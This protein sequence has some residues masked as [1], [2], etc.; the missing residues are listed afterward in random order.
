MLRASFPVREGDRPVVGV[1]VRD[2]VFVRLDREGRSGFGECAP[3]GGGDAALRACQR[4]LEAWA[5][6]GATADAA[7]CLPPP[8]RFAASAAI[9][10][11]EGFGAAAHAPV[12]AAA[13]F[14]A[15]P[16]ALDDAALDR[17]R[18]GAAIK[19]KIGRAPAAEERRMLE[20]IL[21][22]IPGTRLRLDGNRGMRLDDCVAL[23]QG[24]PV[25]RFEYLEEPV[26]DPSDLGRLRDCTGIDVALDE[27]VVDASAEARDL[28]DRLGGGAC[29]WVIR[30]SRI[31]SLDEVRRTMRIAASR[32]CDPVLSTAYESSWTIRLAAH[33]ARSMDATD[34]PHGLGTADVLEADACVPA[35][36]ASECVPCGPLPV[37]LE[38]RW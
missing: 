12:G 23:V 22:D 31:G 6:A 8:A 27:L 7:A 17:L 32:G 11:L 29:A 35:T 15:G 16:A 13:Y 10:T 1:P 14:G 21:R 30:L 9:E 19:V 37:P 36:L 5:S 34:R 2:A 28:R 4:A 24:L 26:A 3:L 38:G 33:L 20:R 25:E 18:H